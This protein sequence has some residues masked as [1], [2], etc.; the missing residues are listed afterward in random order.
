MGQT[1]RPCGK[2]EKGQK[3]PFSVR[4]NGA[5]TELCNQSQLSQRSRVRDWSFMRGSRVAMKP[6]ILRLAPSRKVPRLYASCN[7][8]FQ[9][10]LLLLIINFTIS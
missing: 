10:H 5:E 1:K 7:P 4:S 3:F 6:K 8:F 9:S 2:V